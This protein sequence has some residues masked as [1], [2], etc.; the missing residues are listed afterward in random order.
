V[1]G[2]VGVDGCRG[3]WVAVALPGPEVVVRRT[4]REVLAAFPG[5]ACVAVDM[6][7]GLPSGPGGRASDRAAKRLLGR[8]S[9]RVFP[10]PTRACLE[11]PTYA[12]ARLVEPSLSAQSYALRHKIGEAADAGRHG[13]VV[14]AHPELAFLAFAGNVLVSKRTWDGLVRRRA[15]LAGQGLVLPDDLGATGGTAAADDVLDAAACALV[16]QA[17]L[18]GTAERLGDPVEGVIWMPARAR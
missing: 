2:V 11:L 3:G 8:A 1:A 4:L 9:S 7:I 12:A 6:P 16:A 5:A 13:P 14:E 17:V 18:D 15:V 10:A